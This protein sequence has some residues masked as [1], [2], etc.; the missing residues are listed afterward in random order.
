MLHIYIVFLLLLSRAFFWKL[1]ICGYIPPI[2][3]YEF[4]INC[5][6]F[7]VSEKLMYHGSVPNAR[8]VRYDSW[9]I[10]PP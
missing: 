6:E 3:I 8:N 10:L 1:R 4:K 7:K 2:W 9:L 5:E